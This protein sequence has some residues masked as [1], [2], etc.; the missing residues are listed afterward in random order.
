MPDFYLVMKS[1]TEK[2]PS[3]RGRIQGELLVDANVTDPTL[4]A[5]FMQD[6][7]AVRE[8]EI[9]SLEE[10]ASFNKEAYEKKYAEDIVLS[11]VYKYQENLPAED[12]GLAE[13]TYDLKLTAEDKDGKETGEW[14][15]KGVTVENKAMSQSEKD[16]IESEWQ[17]ATGEISA[18]TAYYDKDHKI[19][20]GIDE[21]GGD[22]VRADQIVL[23]GWVNA[24]FTEDEN[25]TMS[26]TVEI[27]GK[28]YTTDDLAAAGGSVETPLAPR[29]IEKDETIAGD[30]RG[31]EVYNSR[32][33]G[34]IIAIS[35]PN[36]TEGSHEIV[37]H[38]NVPYDGEGGETGEGGSLLYKMDPVTV[39]VSPTAPDSSVE[40]KKEK[41][42]KQ[43]LDAFPE[44]ARKELESE[45][46]SEQQ[47]E[48]E[49]ES[50]QE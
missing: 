46:E 47:S 16:K 43:W 42:E 14:T 19:G 31:P 3:Y 50:G 32:N 40:E 36:L 26:A 21:A 22:P 2:S 35:L 4:T 17:M 28:E 37:I 7:K 12:L 38:Y 25:S 41:I 48:H 45:G 20:V 5:E 27:D 49:P 13:G 24:P 33:A 8:A 10:K 23:T 29:Y 15:I 18:G 6:G 44:E 34:V 11:N 39:S 9:G 1:P 30:D